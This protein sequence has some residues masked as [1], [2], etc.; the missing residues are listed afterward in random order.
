MLPYYSHPYVHACRSEI[1][2]ECLVLLLRNASGLSVNYISSLG[3]VRSIISQHSVNAKTMAK[4][5][6]GVAG[7][8]KF[9]GRLFVCYL[10]VC[11][12]VWF[13]F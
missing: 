7:V 6:R 5:S 11:L 2:S 13:Y 12:L 8:P 1:A 9:N 3:L 10:S 4:K